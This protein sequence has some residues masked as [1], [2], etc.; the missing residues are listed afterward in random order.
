M[1]SVRLPPRG[2]TPV[3]AQSP[4]RALPAQAPVK[5]PLDGFD[6]RSVT[7]QLLQRGMTGAVVTQ[8]QQKLVAAKF[9]SMSDF[10]S[11][12]GVYG[13]RTEAAVK[14]LQGFVGLPASGVAGPSTL[15]ALNSGVRFEERRPVPSNPEETAPMSRAAVHARLAQTFSDDVTQ[16]IVH[17]PD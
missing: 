1:T 5:R 12:P 8:F 13:P 17:R 11:G 2:S 16:P 7:A 3:S 6:R 14:R 15:A 10:K 9:M 4:A